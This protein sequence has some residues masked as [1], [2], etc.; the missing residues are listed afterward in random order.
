[1]WSAKQKLKFIPRNPKNYPPYK[2]KLRTMVDSLA[3][4][5]SMDR[6]VFLFC[7]TATA[8]RLQKSKNLQNS[9]KHKII[10]IDKIDQQNY[11]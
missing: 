9:E 2:W 11:T 7:Q 1:M 6:A 4:A 3:G 8:W 5:V 10:T